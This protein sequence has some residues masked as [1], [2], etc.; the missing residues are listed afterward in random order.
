MNEWPKDINTIPKEQLVVNF[1]LLHSGKIKLLE[2]I[3]HAYKKSTDQIEKELWIVA[4]FDHAYHLK[5]WFKNFP[6][7][8]DF[9][10]VWEKYKSNYYFKICRDFCNKNKHVKVSHPSISNNARLI[11]IY[12]KNNVDNYITFNNKYMP[13]DFLMEKVLEFWTEFQ[14]NEL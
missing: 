5:D 3:L 6:I 13:A 1:T 7:I 14:R 9:K 8:S 11:K 12:T 2:Y 4:F 10:S